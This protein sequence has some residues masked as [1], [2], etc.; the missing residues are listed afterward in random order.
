MKITKHFRRDAARW[1]GVGVAV[2]LSATSTLALAQTVPPTPPAQPD[3]TA[4][5]SPQSTSPWAAPASI[6]SP[7]ISPEFVHELETALKPA[8]T[9]VQ[10]DPSADIAPVSLTHAL[11]GEVSA[12][13]SDL[14]K[15]AAISFQSPL[16]GYSVNSHF[17]LRQLSFEG[18][19]RMHKGVDIAAPSGSEIHA[20]ADGYVTRTGRSSSYGHFVEV[21]HADGMSS[22]YAH[23]SR[24][25][26]LE[27][28]TKVSA[29]D[30]LGYVGSTGR[31]T[32][33]HLHFEIRSEGE[34]LD[35]EAFM[36]RDFA[37]AAD[38]PLTQASSPSVFNPIRHPLRTLASWRARRRAARIHYAI[39][40]RSH[41]R[42]AAG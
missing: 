11:P 25:A 3:A 14:P 2:G 24:T 6:A 20:T 15:D 7:Q 31:S 1:I 34:P 5:T 38:L 41:A 42:A 21:A 16:P 39:Y 12:A 9:P 29:G 10:P 35:P 19:A 28:G 30:V 32:G 18:H 22:F 27:P 26:G 17:G 40:H 36:G 8:P 33:P 13:V 4:S 37:S 23:M